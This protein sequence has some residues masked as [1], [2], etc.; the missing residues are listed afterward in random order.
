MSWKLVPVALV[1]VVVAHGAFAA[2]LAPRTYTKAPVAT[3]PVFNWSGPYVGVNLGY[4][5]ASDPVKLAFTP[6]SD[7]GEQPTVAPAGW[8]GGGQLGY[9]YQA[10]RWVLGVEGDVQATALRQSICFDFCNPSITFRVTQELPWFATMR[11]RVGYAAGPALIYATGGAAFTSVKTALVDTF[12]PAP[13][14]AGT[15]NDVRTG[16]VVGGG[17]EA[18]L[19]GHWTAKAEYLYLDFGTVTHAMSDTFLGPSNPN[20][21]AI[22]VREQVFRVG[23][24]YL[25]DDPGRGSA[26]AMIGAPPIMAAAHSWSG[27]YVGGNLGAAAGAGPAAFGGDNVVNNQSSFSPRALVGGLQAG[28]NWQAQ[29]LVFGIEGDFQLD[30]QHQKDCYDFCLPTQYIN[31]DERLPWFATERLRVGYAMG[32]LLIYATGG[33]AQGKAETTYVN[34]DGILWSSGSFADV[35]SGWTAGG[36]LEAALTDRWSVKAEYLYLD[37]GHVDHA[38]PDRFFEGAND[39]FWSTIHD[40]IFRLGVNY[41]VAPF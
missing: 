21:F 4:G 31:F 18:M 12:A 2:D 16:W 27:L 33:A 15:F 38:M 14:V 32:P 19:G 36:G 17:I 8:L 7:G 9:N 6:A 35:K 26:F 13:D 41:K 1:A 11:G 10:G 28:V 40:H 29:N 37:L 34:Y 3:D 5:A 22:G 30:G 24:N 25:L 20:V 39:N 23:L